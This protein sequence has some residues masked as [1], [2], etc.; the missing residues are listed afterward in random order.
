MKQLV[1]LRHGKAEEDTMDK[2]DFD[3]VLTERGR[4]SAKNMGIFILQK[5]GVPDLILSSSARRAHDTAIIA[6]KC[7]GYPQD[8]IKADQNLYFAPARWIQNVI[9]KL[10]NEINSCLY[11]GHNPGITDLINDFGVRLDYLPTAS[12]VCFEFQVDS[13]SDIAPETA[14]FLWLKLSRDL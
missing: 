3:R 8:D 2:D 1:V 9:S 10:P 13:W 7:L 11:V 5:W 4:Q 6:T 12:A 14:N